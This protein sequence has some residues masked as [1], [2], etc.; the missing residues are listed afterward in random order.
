LFWNNFIRQACAFSWLD[1]PFHRT[2][3]RHWPGFPQLSRS[4]LTKEPRPKSDMPI[5]RSKI[6]IGALVP[7]KSNSFLL[8]GHSEAIVGWQVDEKSLFV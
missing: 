2:A 1:E 8:L 3:P 7:I 4:L 5:Q 6:A